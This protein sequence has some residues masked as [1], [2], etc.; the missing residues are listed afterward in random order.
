MGSEMCIRDS[1]KSEMPEYLNAIDKEKEDPFWVMVTTSMYDDGKQAY[2]DDNT[3]DSK[4]KS[5]VVAAD[6]V[7]VASEMDDRGKL[8]SSH[9]TI[10]K[11]GP[12]IAEEVIF[13]FKEWMSSKVATETAT[14]TAKRVLLHCIF[15][16]NQHM[17]RRA[18]PIR[19]VKRKIV[20]PLSR[21]R[22]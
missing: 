7:P 16:V 6:L 10:P 4:S 11:K 14:D 12:A 22:T 21:R 2:D 8:V 20:Y 13:P 18:L 17:R 1:L 9:Q 5:A 19:M 15:H 3:T